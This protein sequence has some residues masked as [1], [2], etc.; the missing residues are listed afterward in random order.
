VSDVYVQSAAAGVR[1]GQRSAPAWMSGVSS[2]LSVVDEV[3]PSNDH[4]LLSRVHTSS[5]LDDKPS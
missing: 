1:L 5:Q 2:R 3:S 4:Q